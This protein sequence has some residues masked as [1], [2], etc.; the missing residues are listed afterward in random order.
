V[1]ATPSPVVTYTF[2]SVGF[3]RASMGSGISRSF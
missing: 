2:T 1:M 3:F